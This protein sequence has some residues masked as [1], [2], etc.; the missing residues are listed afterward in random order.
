MVVAHIH[1]FVANCWSMCAGYHRRDGPIVWRAHGQTRIKVET[2]ARTQTRTGV[3]IAHVCPSGILV[4]QLAVV[5]GSRL[6]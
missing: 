6:I 1:R 2:R 5:R 3:A 4:R